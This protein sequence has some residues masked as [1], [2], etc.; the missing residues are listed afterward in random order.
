[1]KATGIVRNI[2]ELGRLVLPKELRRHLEIANDTPVEITSEDDKIIIKRFNPRCIFCNDEGTLVE[3]KGKRICHIC[4]DEL[5][6][7]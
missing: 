1:M 7:I 5:A 3:F 4:K 6:R 2:D